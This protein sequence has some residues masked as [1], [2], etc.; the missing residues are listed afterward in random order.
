MNGKKI[1]LNMRKTIIYFTSILFVFVLFSC[2]REKTA[3]DRFPIKIDKVEFSEKNESM[4]ISGS[5]TNKSGH[6]VNE[7]NLFPRLSLREG[8]EIIEFY[9]K[10]EWEL[11]N[12]VVLN[13]NDTKRFHKT[14]HIKIDNPNR[15]RYDFKKVE[16]EISSKAKN[17]LGYTSW[18][19]DRVIDY[20]VHRHKP[21]KFN[22]TEEWKEYVLLMRKK[23]KLN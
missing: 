2:K 11:L 10:N 21:C 6:Y 23:H 17:D 5:V 1:T 14:F 4:T 16:L 7:L 15:F 20:S 22:I 13:N 9:E 18:F 19:G 8:V 12:S 3:C